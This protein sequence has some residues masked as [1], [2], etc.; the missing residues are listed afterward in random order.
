[1]VARKAA[2]HRSHATFFHSCHGTGTD[3]FNCGSPSCLL[4]LSWPIAIRKVCVLVTLSPICIAK[5]QQC[6]QQW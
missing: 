2:S 5:L 6:Q 1:V 3:V 4:L